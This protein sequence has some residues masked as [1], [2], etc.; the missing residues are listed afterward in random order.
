MGI[1]QH[2]G[3]TV[4]ARSVT[5]L[6]LT[7]G[8]QN[9][10]QAANYLGSAADFAVLA[11]ST[12]TTTG[13]T[14]INGD[15]GVSPGTAFTVTGT[16]NQNG[17]VH[18]A[19]A[20]ALLAQTDATNA[21]SA[22]AALAPTTNLTGFDLGLVGVLTPGVYRFDSSAQ[23]TGT[24]TL[25]YASNPGGAFIFQI[26]STL[27]TASGASVLTLNGGAGSGLYW[28]VGSAATLGSGTTFAGNILA[29]S[30]ISLDPGASI[31]CGRAIALTAAVTMIG[32][33][34]S[35]NCGGGGDYGSGRSDFGSAGFLGE[36]VPEP[37]SWALMIAGFGLTGA[38]M[39]RRPATA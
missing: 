34:I 35:N 2:S 27:T 20:V 13:V 6:L 11:A 1:N 4:I 5:L 33:V 23:L 32:N 7:L 9:Q 8:W 25:D 12:A 3:R 28:N 19:D 29:Q 36:A 24:L 14:T 31:I 18:T 17:T 26:G 22:L 16:L 10:A 15:V 21:A 37:G 30:A 39:R 38:A